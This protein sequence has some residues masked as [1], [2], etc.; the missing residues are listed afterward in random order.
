MT[1]DDTKINDRLHPKNLVV[2]RAP[3]EDE[4]SISQDSKNFQID[5]LCKSDRKSHTPTK[6]E[7]TNPT[8]K[9]EKDIPFN[10]SVSDG[11]VLPIDKT[12]VVISKQRKSKIERKS[13]SDEKC[14]NGNNSI[15]KAEDSTSVKNIG[16][17][18]RPLH[19]NKE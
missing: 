8:T 16:F 13:I 7:L 9:E 15:E 1:K 5:T 14:V 3:Y 11:I 12:D 19:V 6:I 4:I 18:E 17:C 2:K 10:K